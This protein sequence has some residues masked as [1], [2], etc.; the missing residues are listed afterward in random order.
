M[1]H[2]LEP[3][4]TP[5]S[6]GD[7][8]GEYLALRRSAGLVIGRH[9]LVWV[10]GSDAVGFLQDIISQE[11]EA[12]EIGSTVRSLLLG[13]Q[14]KLRALLWVIRGKDRVGLFADQGV[15]S[16]VVEDLRRYLIRVD[17]S[18]E[19]DARE[20][21]LLVGP[22]SQDVLEA[23]GLR[24]P[25]GWIED[26]GVLVTRADLGAALRYLIVGGDHTQLLEAGAQAAGSLAY[27]AIRVEAGEPVMD[28]DV[29]EKTI[30]QEADLVASAINLEK[31]CYLGQE[32]VARIESRGRVNRHLRGVELMT[33][34]VPPAG[35]ALV[36]DA[37][38]VGSI[39]SVS[40]SLSLRA[41]IALAL[42]RRELSPG[43]EVTVSWEQGQARALLR[44]LPM[45]D[46]TDS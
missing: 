19:P 34:V 25:R 8:T 44:E 20:V 32:L 31:G 30:P 2:G 33:N 26:S 39:S 21:V 40:E 17:V 11:V 5:E 4:P 43:H 28:Q 35:A 29:D 23:A 46:F 36:S 9:Q 10:S 6:Y 1:G 16:R 3:G 13:P 41:P 14:G 22:K 7:V 37:R 38:E 15:G 24:V 27:S 18:V 45:D 12:L 42:V